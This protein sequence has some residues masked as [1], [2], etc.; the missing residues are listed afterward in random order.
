MV[1]KSNC[2]Q[3][4]CWAHLLRDSKDLAEHY[5]EAKYIHKRLKYIYAKAK[6]DERRENLLHWIDSISSRSYKS[7]EVHKFVKSICRAHRD[8][9]FRFVDNPEIDSINNPMSF[10]TDLL[11][12]GK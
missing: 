10:M 11:Y 12:K 7:S 3:Q 8:N 5:Q 9:L 1:K 2:E 4:I 6:D